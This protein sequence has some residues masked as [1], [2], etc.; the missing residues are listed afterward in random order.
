ME[1]SQM[2]ITLELPDELEK[3][4]STEA[5][6]LGLPLSDYVLRVL[7]AGGSPGEPPETGAE[8]VDYWRRE[9][10]V[11]TREGIV[12]SSEHARELRRR[13]ETRMSG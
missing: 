6:R 5:A 7:A 1:T 4:L 10:L 9:G 8:L 2:T 13:A 3:V 12:D 11:G